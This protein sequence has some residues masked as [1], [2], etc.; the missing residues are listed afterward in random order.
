V[1][2]TSGDG[3]CPPPG[4]RTRARQAGAKVVVVNPHAS[5][6][7]GVAHLVLRGHRGADAAGLAL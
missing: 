6:L 2:G 4:S 5:E 3:L 1:V 7:D